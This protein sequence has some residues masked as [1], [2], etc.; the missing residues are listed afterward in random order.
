MTD[1]TDA[2]PTPKPEEPTD[3]AWRLEALHI[4]LCLTSVTQE[5]VGNVALALGDFITELPSLPVRQKR[6][7]VAQMVAAKWSGMAQDA[8]VPLVV[9]LATA[10]VEDMP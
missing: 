1:K 3:A 9:A 5:R 10:C 2:A 4:A 6:Y 7:R 8:F